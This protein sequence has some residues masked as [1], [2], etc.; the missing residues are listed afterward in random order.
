MMTMIIEFVS[1]EVTVI[2]LGQIGVEKQAT[3]IVLLNFFAV[4]LMLAFGYQQ[5]SCALVGQQIGASNLSEARNIWRKLLTLF[6]IS[7][8]ILWAFLYWNRFNVVSIYT[9]EKRV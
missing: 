5:A 8:I 1:Y 6:V 3:Q 4:P 7:D 9:T 2:Y